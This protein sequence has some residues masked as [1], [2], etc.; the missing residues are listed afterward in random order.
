MKVLEVW[1]PWRASKGV[2]DKEEGEKGGHWGERISTEATE[3]S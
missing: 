3:E 2:G 1:P